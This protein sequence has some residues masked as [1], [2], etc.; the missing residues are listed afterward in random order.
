M[1]KKPSIADTYITWLIAIGG[2]LFVLGYSA[3]IGVIALVVFLIYC[4][5]SKGEG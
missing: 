1:S 4:I 3:I 2:G 5:F